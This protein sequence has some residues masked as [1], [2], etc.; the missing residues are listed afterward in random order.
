VFKAKSSDGCN[1]PVKLVLGL[2]SRVEH[3]C[4]FDDQPLQGIV[5]LV[6]LAVD[7][8]LDHHLDTR[9]VLAVMLLA[10]CLDDIHKTV[11]LEFTL[12]VLQGIGLVSLVDFISPLEIVTKVFDVRGELLGEVNQRNL[13]TLVLNHLK[14]SVGDVQGLSAL[15]SVDDIVVVGVV[16]VLEL[17]NGHLVTHVFVDW[18]FLNDLGL[19]NNHLLITIGSSE[20]FLQTLAHVTLQFFHFVFLLSFIDVFQIDASIISKT[21]NMSMVNLRQFSEF[22]L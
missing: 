11:I 9:G 2:I 12:L 17:T 22:L 15:H 4:L 14:F 16:L 8:G 3:D 10:E 5:T 1:L 13:L 19:P 6:L 18:D 20:V 21:C 7:T